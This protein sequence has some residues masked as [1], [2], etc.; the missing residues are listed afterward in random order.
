MVFNNIFYLIIILEKEEEKEIKKAQ[1]ERNQ[2]TLEND[3][4]EKNNIDVINFTLFCR[5]LNDLH[6]KIPQEDKFKSKN[7][8]LNNLVAFKIFDI[9]KDGYVDIE[10]LKK[11]YS[12]IFKD[13]E[14]PDPNKEVNIE[15]LAKNILME[16]STNE[17]YKIDFNNFQKIIL[18]SNFL[19]NL[20]F[21]P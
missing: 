10:D 1:K 6:I 13:F 15:N 18:S 2:F 4:L 12:I 19:N 5:I 11:A 14:S 16:F 9:D 17:K 7:L 21:M 20:V 3:K 8:K